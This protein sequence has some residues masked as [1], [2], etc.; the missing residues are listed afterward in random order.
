MLEALSM[1]CTLLKCSTL[2]KITH[3][4]ILISLML[5]PI[6]TGRTWMAGSEGPCSAG[7]VRMS[8]SPL[9]QHTIS[10]QNPASPPARSKTRGKKWEYTQVRG[11]K[12]QTNQPCSHHRGQNSAVANLPKPFSAAASY[13]K[14]ALERGGEKSK[15]NT[16]DRNQAAD[17]STWDAVH[18]QISFPTAARERQERRWGRF[19]PA[20][21]RGCSPCSRT[22]QGEAPGGT[23]GIWAALPRPPAPS[24]SQP[25][26]ARSLLTHMRLCPRSSDS[27]V[28]QEQPPANSAARHRRSSGEP[29]PE[30]RQPGKA[31]RQV[32]AQPT[33]THCSW[34]EQ[35]A[36]RSR[37]QGWTRTTSREGSLLTWIAA[38]PWNAPAG[39]RCA[40]TS[41][42]GG[43]LRDPTEMVPEHF[44]SQ[45]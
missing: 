37:K 26:P 12:Y 14:T 21:A 29:C 36:S 44:S 2:D 11:K 31:S 17:P 30:M 19:Q 13:Q 6:Y 27:P 16:S 24:A 25:L 41:H 20:L 4:Q 45:Q 22:A 32:S 9:L 39:T 42:E 23:P 43:S 3:G 10:E 28:L 18:R 35:L 1:H 7:C 38:C 15:P 8:P 40:P 34:Q 33:P 5:V